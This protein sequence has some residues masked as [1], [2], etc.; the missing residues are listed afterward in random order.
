VTNVVRRYTKRGEL[1]ATFTLEDLDAA[2]E[3]FVFPKTMLEIGG[4]LE[5]DAIVSV[6]GRIDSSRDDEVKLI[7]LDVTRPTLVAEGE[8]PPLEVTIPLGSLSESLVDRLRE[9]VVDHPGP[10][11]IYLR[12]GTKTLRLPPEFNVDPKSGLVGA[13]LE[14]FGPNAVGSNGSD[15]AAA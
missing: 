15:P 10:T 7:A 4:R 1:M 3:V 5:T 9:L 14:L 13:L 11:P 8:V 2:I 6:R 12:V